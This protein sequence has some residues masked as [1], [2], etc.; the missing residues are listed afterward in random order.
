[1]N[2]LYILAKG[3]HRLVA[4]DIPGNPREGSDEACIALGVVGHI[5]GREE[6]ARDDRAAGQ[7][8][9][10]VAPFYR[11]GSL[12]IIFIFSGL[13]FLGSEM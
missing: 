9:P 8:P 11:M 6:I 1:V 5:M 12:M 4:S 2:P 3:F 13:R 7:C 10:P